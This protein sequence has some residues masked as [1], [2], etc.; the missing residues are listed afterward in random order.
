M[1]KLIYILPLIASLAACSDNRPEW[2][3]RENE[4]RNNCKTLYG[5]VRGN[6]S[7]QA[8]YDA[9]PEYCECY[10]HI[11]TKVM[12][13]AE[14]KNTTH[15]DKMKFVS[16]VLGP[17]YKETLDE[18]EQEQDTDYV[19]GFIATASAISACGSLTNRTT[20]EK[21]NKWFNFVDNKINDL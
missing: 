12:V 13:W 1:K 16:A 21:S 18:W 4:I 15:K 20:P 2:Q 19:N 7:P 17:D 9:A 8:A 5:L 6:I 10:S 3:T 11:Y 14:N